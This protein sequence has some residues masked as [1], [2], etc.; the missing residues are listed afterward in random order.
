[1]E[2]LDA[3][4]RDVR[5][6]HDWRLCCRCT[7]NISQRRQ[8][9]TDCEC[10][11]Q[12]VKTKS[13]WLTKSIAGGFSSVL[14]E[15]A[16][17]FTPSTGLSGFELFVVSQFGINKVHLFDSILLFFLI[18]IICC[19]GVFTCCW[20]AGPI[21][22]FPGRIK[23]TFPT[24]SQ[25]PHRNVSSDVPSLRARNNRGWVVASSLTRTHPLANQQARLA[26]LAKACFGKLPPVVIIN[27]PL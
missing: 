22:P 3:L 25:R 15:V 6:H 7:L 1:M 13:K 16:V 26:H 10:N 19:F 20:R 11:Q 21:P 14:F 12:H 2:S 9:T 27:T 23:H 18:C 8:G 5:Q 17:L 4:L 24:E